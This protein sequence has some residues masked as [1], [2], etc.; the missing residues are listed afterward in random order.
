MA[1]LALPFF[2]IQKGNIPIIPP[3]FLSENVGSHR[4]KQEAEKICRWNNPIIR[5]PT[6]HS[7]L[8][9]CRTESNG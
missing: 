7:M 5:W 6:L 3:Y 1:Y 4:I 9:M 8:K 2:L